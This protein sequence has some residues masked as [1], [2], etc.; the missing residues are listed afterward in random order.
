MP[1]TE[2][3][4]PLETLARRLQRPVESLRACAALSEAEQATL[5]A[6]IERALAQ[7]SVDIDRSLAR[8][9]PWPLRAPLLRWMRR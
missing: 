5:L 4:G 7:R 3:G 6:A 1:T 8:L 2:S 9:I